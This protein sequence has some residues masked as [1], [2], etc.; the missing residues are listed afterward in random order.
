MR[1]EQLSGKTGS[2]PLSMCGP[3]GRVMDA[4]ISNMGGFDIILKSAH[5]NCKGLFPKH[6]SMSSILDFGR[7]MLIATAS[8][9]APKVPD[10]GAKPRA[11]A[12]RM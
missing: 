2:I 12:V 6:I 1:D 10:F 9:L 8:A 7:H 5:A 3:P 11:L 4:H